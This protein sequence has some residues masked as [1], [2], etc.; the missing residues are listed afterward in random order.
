MGEKAGYKAGYEK[1][2]REIAW[3][4]QR[5][6]ESI[7]DR[8][9]N[10]TVTMDIGN[11]VKIEN[12]PKECEPHVEVTVVCKSSDRVITVD[13]IIQCKLDMGRMFIGVA[14][15][16]YFSEQAKYYAER[17]DILL[18]DRSHLESLGACP[19]LAEMDITEY[20]KKIAGR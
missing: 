10:C 20:L 5:T 11:F 8:Q 14:T 13:D 19:I 16:N 3:Y 6:S 9:F 4:M 2:D 7:K 1:T 17:N 15:N 18:I 12:I